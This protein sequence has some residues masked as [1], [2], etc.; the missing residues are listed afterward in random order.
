[1]EGQAITT[2]LKGITLYIIFPIQYWYHIYTQE[3]YRC[4]TKIETMNL[5]AFQQLCLIV[6]KALWFQ[7]EVK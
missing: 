7:A 1:M 3:L 2:V 6:H 5:Q 4:C